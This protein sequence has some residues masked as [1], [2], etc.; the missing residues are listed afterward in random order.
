MAQYEAGQ[1][2]PLHPKVKAAVGVTSVLAAI[3]TVLAAVGV[4]VPN[5][6]QNSASIVVA[7]IAAL[8]PLVVAY[9]KSA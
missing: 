4:V 1:S 8:I 6:V 5:D 7:D 2:L 3:F 9:L